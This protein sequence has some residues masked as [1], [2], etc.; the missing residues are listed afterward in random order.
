MSSTIDFEPIC[1]LGD[2][3]SA[4]GAYSG[5]TRGGAFSA[6]YVLHGGALTVSSNAYDPIAVLDSQLRLYKSPNL[7]DIPRRHVEVLLHCLDA[8]EPSELEAWEKLQAAFEN[9]FDQNEIK[10]CSPNTEGMWYIPVESGDLLHKTGTLCVQLK[11]TDDPTITM[12]VLCNRTRNGGA[13]SPYKRR[14]N[15]DGTDCEFEWDWL[16]DLI[17]ALYVQIHGFYAIHA[18]MVSKNSNAVLVGG[19][20]GSGKSTTALALTREGFRLHTDDYGLIRSESDGSVRCSGLLMPPRLVGRP[21]ES[22]ESLEETI[23]RP[24][25]QGKYPFEA[26]C[27]AY[28]EDAQSWRHPKVVILL[29]RTDGISEHLVTPLHGSE[30]LSG[31]MG[32]ALDPLRMMRLEAWMDVSLALIHECD[33]YRI[34]A[35]ADLKSLARRIDELLPDE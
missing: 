15:F 22:V 11:R 34:S 32:L 21:P 2:A 27:T 20:S 29:D 33:V 6:T 1:G 4:S 10:G 25:D 19:V 28:A 17:K 18:A 3:A 16:I 8:T 14:R 35:G 31:V 9:R 5:E 13:A 30:A 7:S 26:G 23:S 12:S 24:R